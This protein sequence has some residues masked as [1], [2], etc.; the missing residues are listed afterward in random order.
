MNN[1]NLTNIQ[2]IDQIFSQ[3]NLLHFHTNPNSKSKSGLSFRE[4]QIILLG[5]M[6]GSLSQTQN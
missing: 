3:S 1:R 5:I 2:E 4:K 6:L